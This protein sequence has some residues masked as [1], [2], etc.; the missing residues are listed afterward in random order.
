M[1]F[2]KHYG[3]TM[4]CINVKCLILT[5]FFRHN[6]EI[7]W[8]NEGGEY[9]EN[10][11]VKDLILL[12]RKENGDDA[13]EDSLRLQRLLETVRVRVNPTLLSHPSWPWQKRHSFRG[14]RSQ[15]KWVFPS[16]HPLFANYKI[17]IYSNLSIPTQEGSLKKRLW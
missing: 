17:N 4:R 2:V 3:V 16:K 5:I 11:P 14:P 10:S 12:C 13:E 7:Y 6:T 1:Y 8:Y 9:A 15:E